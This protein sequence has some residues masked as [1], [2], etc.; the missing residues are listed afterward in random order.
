MT[1]KGKAGYTGHLRELGD[2]TWSWRHLFTHKSKAMS[3]CYGV[4]HGGSCPEGG[5]SGPGW[6]GAGRED[7][8]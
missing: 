2:Q 7:L 8:R 6:A 1:K 3:N 5:C 4:G